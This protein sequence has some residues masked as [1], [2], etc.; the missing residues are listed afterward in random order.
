MSRVQN[1]IINVQTTGA[2]QA[3]SAIAGIGNES[4][5][6]ASAL[7]TL[8]DALGSVV[9][10]SSIES[11]VELLDTYQNIENRLATV[12]KGQDDL[13]VVT[14]ELFDVAIQSR[15][16]FE[17]TADTYTRLALVTKEF[18]TSSQNL[19]IVTKE[20]NEAVIVG[21]GSSQQAAASIS[22]LIG[23]LEFGTRQGVQLISILRRMPLLFDEIVEHLHVAPNQLAELAKQGKITA[24]TIINALVEAAPEIQAA[25]DKTLPTVAQEL[26]N[27]RTDFLKFIETINGGLNVLKKLD[28]AIEFLQQNM[29]VLGS[30]VIG[31]ILTGAITGLILGVTAL[32]FAIAANP[33][34]AV[35]GALIL[36]ASS[37]ATYIYQADNAVGKFAG[38]ITSLEPKSR[39]SFGAL[40]QAISEA[41]NGGNQEFTKADQVQGDFFRNV[42]INT[43]RT[44]GENFT[45]HME[46]TVLAFR[47]G[48]S[49]I[50]G[51]FGAFANEV[52]TITESIGIAIQQIFKVSFEKVESFLTG[53]ILDYQAGIALIK[54]DYGQLDILAA[55]KK[56][57]DASS[58]T[59]LS[60]SF[61]GITDTFKKAGVDASQAFV[62]SL[63]NK[64]PL[65]D[66]ITKLKAQLDAQIKS[67]NVSDVFR[68]LDV[69][70]KTGAGLPS[71]SGP[72]ATTTDDATVAINKYQ[73]AIDGVEEKLREQG[74]SL[75]AVNT[76]QKINIEYTKQIQ[77]LTAKVGDVSASDAATI[78]SLITYNE[79]LKNQDEILKSIKGSALNYQ[80]N[81]N[82]ANQ[83]LATG[84]INIQQYNLYVD[85][86]N[87]SLEETTNTL[88]GGVAVGFAQVKTSIDDNITQAANIVTTAF[89]G[90]E[91][92]LVKFTLTGKA[93]FQSLCTEIAGDLEKLLLNKALQSLLGA[94][95]TGGAG[96]GAAALAGSAGG[97]GGAGAAV[98]GSAGG[99]GGAGASFFGGFAAG[100][101][102]TDPN[103]AYIVGENGPEVFAPGASG[104][105][106]PNGALSAPQVNLHVVNVS[107][108]NELSSFLNSPEA[109]NIIVNQVQR[110]N[111]SVKQALS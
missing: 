75:S 102:S 101:A 53:Y 92:A 52:V 48:L 61:K 59:S 58:D 72:S 29:T 66:G 26:T 96:G 40:Q 103:A 4:L 10:A 27:L 64:G 94:V 77:E 80:D 31:T 15:T 99:A 50:L 82:A 62:D 11:L 49:A 87:K 22:Q 93:N 106:I 105:I 109:A 85:K 39:A 74:Q 13:R 34:F 47:V 81:L 63:T 1:I 33:L 98:A 17:Q 57:N 30:V 16:A 100:G 14:A 110:N 84:A 83:L 32:G 42:Q 56:A 9:G 79:Q 5:S 51:N 65:A 54:Q 20:L 21:G 24:E 86:L 71:P 95:A 44:F 3:Q 43:G 76:Q 90:M 2:P 37:F 97:A 12:T 41:V 25:F 7:Q 8:Q 69:N 23:A 78:K 45:E 60:D 67:D 18:G 73:T 91:D 107:D 111:K 46:A 104:T 38:T 89:N 70:P 55:A 28:D 88:E 35:G 36:G 68:G 6:T 108:P 19:L